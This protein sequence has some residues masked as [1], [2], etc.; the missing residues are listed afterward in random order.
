MLRG[1]ASTKV[2]PVDPTPR[3]EP[4]I[5]PRT[6]G[7]TGE[8]AR[9]WPLPLTVREG[10]GGR[11]AVPSGEKKRVDVGVGEMPNTEG[12]GTKM[13]AGGWTL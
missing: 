13:G 8:G 7:G 1:K 2:G 11:P 9:E 5:P 4:P 12:D 10:R 6:V 3:A